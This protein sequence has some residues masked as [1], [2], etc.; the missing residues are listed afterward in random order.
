MYHEEQG[1]KYIHQ[2]EIFL[3]SVVFLFCLSFRLI[4]ILLWTTLK[5]NNT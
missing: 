4:F 3:N 5:E 2:Y 1:R